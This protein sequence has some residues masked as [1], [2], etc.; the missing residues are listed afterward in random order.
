MK[1]PTAEQIRK[2]RQLA[3]LTQRHAAEL[4]GVSVS[5]WEHYEAGRRNMRGRTWRLFQD[6]IAEQKKVRALEFR[7]RQLEKI[8]L[9]LD[10]MRGEMDLL[11]DIAKGGGHD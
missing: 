5:Q 11:V 3:E 8:Q 4:V 1:A 10:V 7:I 2:Q 9:R 6:R